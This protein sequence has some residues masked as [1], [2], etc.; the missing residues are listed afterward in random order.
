METL[1]LRT[2]EINIHNLQ[3]NIIQNLQKESKNEIK[4]S[5]P[6]N[7]SLNILRE[8]ANFISLPKLF[9]SFAPRKENTFWPLIVFSNGILTVSDE[10]RNHS[11]SSE[12]CMNKFL[13]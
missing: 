5:N 11:L 8:C 12:H 13:K 9:Q 2:N 7:S 4:F 3:H 6:F 1:I 10:R